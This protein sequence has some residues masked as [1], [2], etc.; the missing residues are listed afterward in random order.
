[1]NEKRGIINVSTYFVRN[2]FEKR[3]SNVTEQ[4]IIVYYLVPMTVKTFN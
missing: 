2:F 3:V 1:M 4:G